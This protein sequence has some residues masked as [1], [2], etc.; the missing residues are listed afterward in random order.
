MRQGEPAA[1]VGRMATPSAKVGQREIETELSNFSPPASTLYCV[2]GGES[3][4]G[5]LQKGSGGLDFSICSWW[6]LPERR[7]L[8]PAHIHDQT[9]YASPECKSLTN[10]KQ[11]TYVCMRGGSSRM[12]DAGRN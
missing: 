1:G 4:C 11:C 7:D 12:E 8:V 3:A 5:I 6:S 10:N 2:V 9:Y